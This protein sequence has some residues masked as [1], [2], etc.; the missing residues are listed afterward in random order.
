MIDT[1]NLY[2]KGLPGKIPMSISFDVIRDGC[3]IDKDKFDDILYEEQK[4]YNSILREKFNLPFKVISDAACI[5]TKKDLT[6][7][8]VFDSLNVLISLHM[9]LCPGES[10]SDKSGREMIN[11]LNQALNQFKKIRSVS[12]LE[13]KYPDFFELFM[14][15]KTLQDSN[16]KARHLLALNELSGL[17][18]LGRK[19]LKDKLEEQKGLLKGYGFDKKNVNI[20]DFIAKEYRDYK[21]IVDTNSILKIFEFINS[22]E[23]DL[24]KFE[25]VIDEDK[26]KLIF[27]VFYYNSL[28]IFEDN[29]AEF[30]SY[31][32]Y[33]FKEN[34][35]KINNDI[36]VYTPIS[37]DGTEEMVEDDISNAT[38]YKMYKQYLLDHPEA[39]ILFET[40][41]SFIG[42]SLEDVKKYILESTNDFEVYW[43]ILG[44]S[45]ESVYQEVKSQ[46]ERNL[47]NNSD[48]NKIAKLQN[49]MRILEE[50]K[51]FFDSNEPY[52]KIK[53]EKQFDGYV[54]YIYSNGIVALE[55]FYENKSQNKPATAAVYIMEIE[56]FLEFSELSRKEIREEKLCDRITHHRGWQD[57]LSSVINTEPTVDSLERIQIFQNQLRRIKK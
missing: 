34:L 6:N 50:K 12:E 31:L 25:D 24:N 3:A 27:A 38:L 29:K 9:I 22:Y 55:K 19:V 57:K 16:V 51:A 43:D 10:Y 42:K 56:D 32:Y 4:K 11:S 33:Y 7:I 13:K 46:Y 26:L 5:E 30:L 35:G 39:K 8:L 37:K 1:Y 2:N 14:T 44:G 15:L 21:R 40:R 18:S 49:D 48:E 52:L 54:A 28:V 20:T 41:E 47:A 17:D 36:T 53:G 45:T 23:I